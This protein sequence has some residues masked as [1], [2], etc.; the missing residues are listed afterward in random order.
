[1]TVLERQGSASKANSCLVVLGSSIK[2][3]IVSEIS[4]V[5]FSATA[6]PSRVKSPHSGESEVE[7]FRSGEVYVL[8]R[9]LPWGHLDGASS[10]TATKGGE[11]PIFSQ[12]TT[13]ASS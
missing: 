2:E 11:V 3:A 8:M 7:V 6:L 12:E 9:V 1:M 10:L 13:T 5:N 4:D